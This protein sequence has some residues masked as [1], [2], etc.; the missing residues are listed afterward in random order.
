MRILMYCPYFPPQYSGAARQALAL[1]GKLRLIGHSIEFLTIQDDDLPQNDLCNGFPVHRIN[2]NGRRNQE[3][4]LWWNLF[5][6]AWRNKHRFDVMHLHGAHYLSSIVGPISRIVGWPTIVKATMANN[7]LC[8][9]KR[10]AAG[11]FHYFFLKTISAYIAISYDLAREFQASGFQNE[12]IYHIPNGVDTDRFRPPGVQEKVELRNK[13]NLPALKRILLSIGVFD[14][15]KNIGWLIK[16]WESRDGY[17]R[18]SFL[19]AVGP[20]SR[21]DWHGLFLKSLREI[22]AKRKDI[23]VLEHVDDIEN[24]Y[25]AADIFVLPSTNEGLPNVILEAM[26][27]GLPCLATRSSGTKDLVREGITGFLY[28]PNNGAEFS[29]KLAKLDS[30]QILQMGLN[31]RRETRANYSLDKLADT[32]SDLYHK[33]TRRA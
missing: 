33:L 8:G 15:R 14:H 7:D 10:S 16:E 21:E 4:P 9:L 23:R 32:Y 19:L 5:R 13:L 31:G 27:S 17:D 2:V 20:Q 24:Y 26:A 3:M 12:R 28:E 6:F 22:A 25:R 18:D 30:N 29:D 11:F 1:A